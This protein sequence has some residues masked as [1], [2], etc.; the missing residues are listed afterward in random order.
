MSDPTHQFFHAL[1]QGRSDP[2]AGHVRG[3]VRIDLDDDR[4]A[5]TWV[6]HLNHGA[7]TATHRPADAD[8]VVRTD[9]ATFDGLVDGRLNATASLLRGA[10][11][12]RGELEL[13]IYLQRLF[14]APWAEDGRAAEAG[15][16]P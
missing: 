4:G 14:G 1:E 11:E 5:E 16:A 12:A 13:L 15:R 2:R 6:V 3:A 9:R 8:C 7:V 10:I